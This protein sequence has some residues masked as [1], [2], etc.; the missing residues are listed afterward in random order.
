MSPSYDQ[1]LMIRIS[2]RYVDNGLRYYTR[3]RFIVYCIV[4]ARWEHITQ[5]NLVAASGA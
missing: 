2:I 3:F 5:Q 4:L 1:P